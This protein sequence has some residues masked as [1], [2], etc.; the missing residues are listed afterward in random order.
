M[1]RMNDKA[2]TIIRLAQEHLGDPYVYGLKEYDIRVRIVR[3]VIPWDGLEEDIRARFMAWS[4]S[5]EVIDL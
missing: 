2:S 4:E 3:G 1:W 5:G